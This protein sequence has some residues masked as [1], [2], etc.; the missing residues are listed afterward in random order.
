META[1]MK[2]VICYYSG[3]G[4]T[5]LGCEYIATNITN[6]RFELFNIVTDGTPEFSEYDVAGFATFTDYFGVPR[7]MEQF[8]E[9]L[10][11]QSKPAFVFNTYGSMSGKTLKHLAQMATARGFRVI[12]GHSLHTPENY[13]PMISKGLAFR[14]A[15]SERELMKFRIFI[16]SLDQTLGAIKAG[17]AIGKQKIE[18]GL[19][20]SILPALSRTRSRKAMGEKFVDES[21]CVECGT[22][23]KVCPYG[24][25]TLNPKP[26][27]DMEKC[28]GCWA[29][30]NHCPKKAIYTRK[31]RGVG[32]Y[33]SPSKLLREKLRIL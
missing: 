2:G 19:L 24:A 10:E 32:H 28:Y 26:V 12:A 8:V 21:L 7:L 18:F 29:C 25:I 15:P 27:F 30:Y 14:N 1:E 13:P 3:S 31:C 20:N 6:A 16:S 9:G 4:N 17:E 5:R 11:P 22:C 33:P 23:Q